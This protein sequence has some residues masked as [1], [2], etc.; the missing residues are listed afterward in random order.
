MCSRSAFSAIMLACVLG[1]ASCGGDN[2]GDNP[3]NAQS[4][5]PA[6]RT[7]VDELLTAGRE[8][9]RFDTFGDQ[10]F[11]GDTLRLH[12][13]IAGAANGGEGNGVSPRAAL[14]LGLKVD[15]EAL[16][17]GIRDGITAG[18]VDLDAP[19]TTLA[20]L[21][22][23]SV[24]G[25]TGFFDGN[26][27]LTSMGIQCAL[28]HSTVDDSLAPGIG[29]R[30]DGWPNRDLDVGAV[31]AAAPDLSVLVSA[32]GV[33]EETVR[34]VLRSWGPGKFDA[35]L[36]LDG[37]AF[38]PDGGSAATLIPPAYGLAGV[39]L[40]TWTGWG[41]V[42]HWNAFVANL[43]MQGQGTFYDPRLDDPDRFPLA[44]RAGAGHV[45]NDPDLV[46]PKLAALQ[47]YQLALPA[48]TPVA[49]S[50]DAQAAQRGEAVFAGAAR[51]ASCHVPPLFTEPGWN[52]HRAEEIGIDDFQS[53]RSP[54]ERYRTAP[55]RGLSA[56][57]KGGFYH[58]GRFATLAAVVDHYDSF[59]GLGLSAAQRADLIEYLKSL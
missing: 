32:L 42:T 21:E 10:V 37:K 56:H 22:L 19:A 6:V 8:A 23:N 17:R 24:V 18:S 34:T 47:F 54:E 29:R 9:F 15:V 55:L 59:L 35:A 7:Y 27:R 50:F 39:N 2:G 26:R 46:T 16:P 41:S 43:E 51:C 58:D 1:S 38:R 31:I 44:A 20:L 49:G 53:S 4:L 5:E 33:D 11:W 30:L 14:Q 36:L 28:C 48:P 52:L 57:A 13:A 25:V 45:R 3:P 12:Q 40:H